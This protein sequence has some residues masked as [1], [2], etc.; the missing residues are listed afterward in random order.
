MKI[1]KHTGARLDLPANVCPDRPVMTIVVDTEEEFDW[2]APFSRS[3]TDTLSV[4]GQAY[5]HEVFDP[6]GAK[7]TYV[8]DQAIVDSDAAVRFFSDLQKQ[9]LCELGAHLHAWLTPP[10]DEEVNNHNSF[11]GNLPADL[12]FNKI[13]NLRDAI[14]ERFGQAPT[15]F[16]AGRY[17]VGAE[18]FTSLAKLGFK[19]DCSVVPHTSHMEIGGASFYGMSDTPFWLD[20]E[21]GLLSL[22]LT[23]GFT[24]LVSAA[25]PALSFLFD[26]RVYKQMKVPAVLSRTGLIE[27]VTLT[28]EGV[29]AKDQKQLLKRLV[30]SGSRVFS[31]AYHSSSLGV[32]HTPY[33]QS[34]ADLK[35][36]VKT[37]KDVLTYFQQELGGQF[38]S[39]SDIY[40]MAVSSM[41]GSSSETMVDK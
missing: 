24:G 41:G 25:G 40:T 9:G 21:G 22:P 23:R 18:T 19:V 37:L 1:H 26:K 34:K 12:E 2:N 33:V 10:F 14:T 29:P 35:A 16:K 5:A 4:E 3:N 30:N 7:P 11:Q 31:L 15:I 39:V 8:M 38:L 20:K 13:K 36:L 6:L 28:P 32:G 27:R 17:G